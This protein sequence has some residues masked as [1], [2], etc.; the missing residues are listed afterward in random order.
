MVDMQVESQKVF[1]WYIYILAAM[2]WAKRMSLSLA[3]IS[4]NAA[5]REGREG[6]E[7]RGKGRCEKMYGG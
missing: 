5:F 2:Q 4:C 1:G 7:E 3:L 6:R